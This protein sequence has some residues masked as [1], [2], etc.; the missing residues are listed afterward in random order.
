MSQHFSFQSVMTH[1]TDIV[2]FYEQ[3]RADQLT[4]F[5]QEVRPTLDDVKR[6]I[7]IAKQGQNVA[8]A[9]RLI[10]TAQVLDP[11]VRA[12]CSTNVPEVNHDPI[13]TANNDSLSVP[14]T[15]P[16]LWKD[17][18]YDETLYF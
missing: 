1:T 2:R 17:E 18:S 13:T 16:S 7:L 12:S 9:N 11:P 4:V 6:S 15:L 5:Q 10:S 14:Y 3:R 8:E